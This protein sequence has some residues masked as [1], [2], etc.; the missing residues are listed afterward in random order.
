MVEKAVRSN[1]A[2]C[3]LASCSKKGEINI[4][5]GFRLLTVLPPPPYTSGA[6]ALAF[7]QRFSARILPPIELA[8]TMEFR[9][10]MKK[11]EKS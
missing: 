11:G 2:C 1:L 6:T 10:R 8:E 4:A 3:I 5:P 9:D 7:S